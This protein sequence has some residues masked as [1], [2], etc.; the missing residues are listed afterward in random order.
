MYKCT[1]SR[2]CTQKEEKSYVYR[3]TFQ[4]EDT[5]RLIRHIHHVM[6][7][8]D[9]EVTCPRVLVVSGNGARALLLFLVTPLHALG[10]G[11]WL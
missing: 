3:I 1:H 5:K 10:L 2:G 6:L 11:N 9:A 4:E 8:V 7:A